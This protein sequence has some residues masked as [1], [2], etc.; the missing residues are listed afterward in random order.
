MVGDVE[1]VIELDRR[2]TPRLLMLIDVLV[3]G[4]DQ[5]V[6]SSLP[7]ITLLCGV[8]FAVSSSSRLSGC[9]VQSTC[10]R[11]LMLDCVMLVR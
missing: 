10:S 8:R 11:R 2:R 3:V 5:A 6:V 7:F 9:R 4:G 1:D